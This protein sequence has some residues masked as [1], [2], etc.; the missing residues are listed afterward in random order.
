MSVRV[1]NAVCMRCNR[2]YSAA[3]NDVEI[4]VLC[5]FCS[6]SSNHEL[7]E[8]KGLGPAYKGLRRAHQQPSGTLGL[9]AIAVLIV[10]VYAAVYFVVF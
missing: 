10:L 7:I 3:L 4:P 8:R 9:L 1:V 2:L 6:S 5:S